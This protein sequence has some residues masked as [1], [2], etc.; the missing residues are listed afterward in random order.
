MWLVWLVSLAV[1]FILI[2]MRL[3]VVTLMI[4]SMLFILSMAVFHGKS[5]VEHGI[6][7]YLGK[8]SDIHV[9]TTSIFKR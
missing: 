3:L 9:D 1:V 2:R 4:G 8:E 6:Y 5:D 7:I